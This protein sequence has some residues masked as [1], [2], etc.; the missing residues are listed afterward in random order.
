MN[1]KKIYIF[2]GVLAALSSGCGTATVENEI[3]AEIENEINTES[4]IGTEIETKT[5]TKTETE[6]DELTD[7]QTAESTTKI[8]KELS[9]ADFKNLEFYFASGAGGWRTVMT[10]YDDGSFAGQY[11]DSDMG[12]SRYYLSDFSGKFGEP[13]K[14]N[15]YTY[16]LHISELN[17]AKEVGG[18]ELIEGIQYI[19]SDAYGIAN[20]EEI[21][22]YL[23]GAP[24]SELPEEYISWVK[25]EI[26]VHGE[27]VTELPFFGLYNATEECGFSSYDIVEYLYEYIE[28]MEN[29]AESVEESLLKG[30][31]TQIEMNET[32]HELYQ[33]WD[34][35]LNYEWKVLKQVLD[36]DT[37]GELLLEQREWISYKEQ[38]V[39]A[40]YK[41]YEPGSIAPLIA[42]DKAAEL[43]KTRVYELLE[44][45][46]NL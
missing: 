43:T 26:M 30:D 17:Y 22:I 24:L 1:R 32:S 16:S 15:E 13:V 21:L 25:S 45:F 18:E 35:A 19:Y 28:S 20:T 39:L 29:L 3:T 40:V 31:L 46:E 44:Y 27:D 9:F 34:T 4:E 23:P 7:T 6:T 5:E 42:N 10:I 8:Q 38:E 11:S 14:V 36:T 12:A 37:M 33:I 2:I 41:E